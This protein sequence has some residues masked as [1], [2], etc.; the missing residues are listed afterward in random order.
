M[1]NY[2]KYVYKLFNINDNNKDLI[3][4]ILQDLQTA[5]SKTYIIQ[6]QTNIVFSKDK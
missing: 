5:I 1:S 4:K 6:K 3:K 2:V